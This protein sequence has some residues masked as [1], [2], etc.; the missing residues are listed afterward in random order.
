MLKG[1]K[2]MLKK[3]QSSVFRNG[4]I[5][6]HEGLNVVLGDN[7]GSNSIGK[8]TLL[9]IIDFVFGGSS[10]IKKNK[11]TVRNLGHHFFEFIL[12]FNSK[13]YYFRRS[14]KDFKEIEVCNEGFNKIDLW[15]MDD[16]KKFLHKMYMKENDSVKFRSCVGVF[17]RIAQ[18]DNF[19]N[20]KPLKA[21]I[22]SKEIDGVNLLIKLFNMYKSIEDIEKDIKTLDKK[23]SIINGANRYKYIKKPTAKQYEANKKYIETNSKKLNEIAL[24]LSI[25]FNDFLDVN[26]Q[27]AQNELYEAKKQ[28]EMITSKLE[29]VNRNIESNLQI[30]KKSF[31][32][33]QEYFEGVNI[34]KLQEIEEFHK[35]INNILLE[36]FSKA[37]KSLEN[38][39]IEI[40]QQVQIIEEKILDTDAMKNIPN[41][42]LEPLV[43][44]INKLNEKKQENS[45]YEEYIS[46]KEDKEKKEVNLVS[47][48]K[49]ILYT[50]E[51]KINNKMKELNKYIYGEENKYPIFS[52]KE[53]EYF[54]TLP[55]N[56]GTARGYANLIIFDISILK[57][58]IMPFI[59]HDSVMF[60]NIGNLPMGKIIEIYNN[61]KKQCFI[62]IDEINKFT[63]ECQSML[64]TKKVIS[65]SDKDTLFIK[66]WT[67]E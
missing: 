19:F 55:D 49:D 15:S 28:K 29:R 1:E 44:L 31:E 62:A 33:L 56:T 6:F 37:K 63:D 42:L 35:G 3:I 17:S 12:E 22:N 5:F 7:Q 50:I 13:Q 36:E 54:L 9:M 23:I 21:V 43:E 47:T 10:Y 61:E 18:K 25:G 38:K 58:T 65:L 67:K 59:I 40:E 27:E 34:K 45:V 32:P 14:T 11:D 51:V 48:K 4:P 60:K 41:K 26:Y 39:L 66:D 46:D 8:S 16:Y 57:L 53:K 30:K 24:K 2:Y 64:Y 52:I 20:S